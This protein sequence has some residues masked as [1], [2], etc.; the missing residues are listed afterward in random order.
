MEDVNHTSQ[1]PGD[2]SFMKFNFIRMEGGMT[3][4]LPLTAKGQSRVEMK[5]AMLSRLLTCPTV[6]AVVGCIRNSEQEYS[7]T[8]FQLAVG[9]F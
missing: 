8:P 9:T 6:T 5:G 4:S 1:T 3:G 2:V 7:S